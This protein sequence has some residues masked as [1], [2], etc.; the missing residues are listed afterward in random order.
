MQVHCEFVMR[1]Q[2][3]EE[4]GKR[5]APIL[6]KPST[7]RLRKG[8]PMSMTTSILGERSDPE[9]RLWGILPAFSLHFSSFPGSPVV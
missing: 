1:R 4:E 2:E 9:K 7:V 8:F 5:T 3:R 6:R